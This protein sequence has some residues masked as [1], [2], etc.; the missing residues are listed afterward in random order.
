MREIRITSLLILLFITVSFAQSLDSIK[1]EAPSISTEPNRID[2]TEEF[3]QTEDD[4]PY[5]AI[6]KMPEP[7]GGI[8]GIQEKIWYPKEAI[9]NKVEGIV[10]ILAFVDEYG[11]V[12]EAEVL[13]GIGSG[14]DEIA[15]MAVKF[16]QFTPAMLEGKKVKAQISIPIVFKLK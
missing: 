13:K 12:T 6:E 14:C 2:Y 9:K 15:L 5:V 7:I 11:N 3:N 16:T 8:K 10:Y 4:T 1:N